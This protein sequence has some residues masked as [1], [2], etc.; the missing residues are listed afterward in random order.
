MIKTAKRRLLLALVAGVVGCAAWAIVGARS[1]IA[2]SPC[3]PFNTVTLTGT[4]LEVRQGDTVIPNEQ[5]ILDG[6]PGHVCVIG[7]QPNPEGKFIVVTDCDFPEYSV[8][9]MVAP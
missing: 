7:S 6:V 2:M 1:S 3:M 9:A 4:L 8:N 5:S